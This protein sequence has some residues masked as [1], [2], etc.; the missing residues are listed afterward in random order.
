MN[1]VN[2]K[3]EKECRI[4]LAVS[5]QRAPGEGEKRDDPKDSLTGHD[6]QLDGGGDHL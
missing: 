5:S 4:Y 2:T 1:L 3:K 6:R